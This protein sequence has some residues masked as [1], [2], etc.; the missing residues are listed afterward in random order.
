MPVG[1][2]SHF[3]NLHCGH[4]VLWAVGGPVAIICGNHIGAGYGV[5]EGG[6]DNAGLYSLGDIGA[7]YGVPY[8]AI[9]TDPI[10]LVNTALFRIMRVDFQ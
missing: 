7:Q 8:A 4:F 3:I 5:M 10:T 1:R 6:V 9:N 2:L